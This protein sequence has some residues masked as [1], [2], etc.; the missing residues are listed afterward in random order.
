MKAHDK[1]F[2]I[3]AFHEFLHKLLRQPPYP[4]THNPILLPSP[5][6]LHWKNPSAS[7]MVNTPLQEP[8]S[9]PQLRNDYNNEV[10]GQ[11]KKTGPK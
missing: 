9:I 2:L 5:F 6:T 1:L 10:K 7:T 8:Q 3:L 11:R 4:L